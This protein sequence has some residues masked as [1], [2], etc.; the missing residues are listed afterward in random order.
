[1]R[2]RILLLAA[3]AAIVSPVLASAQGGRYLNP[4]DV[5]EAQ[6]EHA[7]LVQELGGAETGARAAYVESV[8]RRVASQTG[9][10]N[11]GQAFRFTTVN[12]AVENAFAVPGG[13]IYVTRQLLGL[14]DDESQLAFA[15]GHE[16]AHVAADHSRARQAYA[17]RNS[18]LGVLGQVLGAV[19]G[20]GGFGGMVSQSAQQAAAMR[21]LSFSRD[22]EYQ[23]DTL[24]LRYLIGSGYDPAGG[25]GILAALTRATALQGQVQG[26]SSRQTPEWASTHPLSTNRMQ[27]AMAEA[28]ASGRLGSGVRNRDGYLAQ[29][30]GIYV[31]DDP[32]Q[33]VIEGP[34][35]THPD[36]RIQFTVPQGYL[37]QNGTYAVTVSGSAGR[38][39]FSGGRYTG[40][41]EDYTMRVY[42]QLTRGQMNINVPPPQRVT[43]NG[44]P[45]AI[46]ATR[47][48][49]RSGGLDVSVVAYQWDAQ[50]VYHFVMLTRAGYGVGPFT[51]MVNSVRRITPAEASAIRPRVIDVVTVA[52]GDTIQSLANRMAY[53]DFR[54][55]RFLSLNGLQPTSA[56]APGQKVKLVV[57]GSRRG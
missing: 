1:M 41:L 38:A 36:L 16:A 39:Q 21:T 53:R 22:Q 45:A 47:V 49:T 11:P 34:T 29:I 51:S 56:L 46:T 27:R 50:R 9:V 55:E 12:S 24:A 10:V 30:D 37:M 57:Y 23:A 13:Y 35:F 31:D 6:R 54:L 19:L 42:Q 7:A 33:G 14:L 5:A 18:V 15:L 25:P 2:K 17:Q 44:M 40:S 48:N 4:S 26:R 43:I 20:N 52:R 28:Q 3:S 8:G 32:E